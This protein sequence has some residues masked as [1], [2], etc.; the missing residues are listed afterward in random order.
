MT[1]YLN[2]TIYQKV[3]AL[4][5]GHYLGSNLMK[6]QRGF[7]FELK[8]PLDCFDKGD[9]VLFVGSDAFEDEDPIWSLEIRP[10]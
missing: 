9:R 8:H 2:V 4:F 7:S 6:S 10:V 1:V 5:K 3:Y